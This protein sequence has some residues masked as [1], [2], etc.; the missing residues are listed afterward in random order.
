MMGKGNEALNVNG[1]TA[2]NLMTELSLVTE[3]NK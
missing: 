2:T 1:V 3:P